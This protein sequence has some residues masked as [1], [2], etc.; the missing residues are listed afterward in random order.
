MI[1]EF[2]IFLSIRSNSSV[3]MNRI[4]HISFHPLKLFCCDESDTL[5]LVLKVSQIL[6]VA[7]SHWNKGGALFATT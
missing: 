5:R 4:L 7:S 3:V 1:S 2:S 6:V